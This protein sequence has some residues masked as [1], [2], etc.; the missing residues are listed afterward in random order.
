VFDPASAAAALAEVRA[1]S[2]D[3]PVNEA[4]LLAGWLRSRLDRDVELEHDEDE[5]V[6]RVAVRCGGAEYVIERHARDHVGRAYGPGTTAHPIVLPILEASTLLGRALDIRAADEV[7]EAA[8]RSAVGK[9][10]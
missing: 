10:A 7:F 6:Q 2:V 4:R 8:L 3:G 9:P 1:V 5:H